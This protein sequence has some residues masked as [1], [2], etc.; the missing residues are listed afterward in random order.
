MKANLK[1]TYNW[2]I[3]VKMIFIEKKCST[4]KEILD[5]QE[6]CKIYRK[7]MQILQENV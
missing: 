6:K 7:K 1:T 2:V 4:E 3:W 5:L